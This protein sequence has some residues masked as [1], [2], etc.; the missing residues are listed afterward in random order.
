MTVGQINDQNNQADPEKPT[1]QAAGKSDGHKP[2]HEPKP[3]P[4]ASVGVGMT[5]MIQFLNNH[6]KNTTNPENPNKMHLRA[7]EVHQ[8]QQEGFKSVQPQTR[9]KNLKTLL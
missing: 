4:P 5:Q 6:S 9:K 8:D 1:A 7:A 3:P 2:R